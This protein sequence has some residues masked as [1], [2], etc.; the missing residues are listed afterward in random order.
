MIIKQFDPQIYPRKLWVVIEPDMGK[1][2]SRF[3]GLEKDELE[4]ETWDAMTAH[5]YNKNKNIG[6]LMV[7]FKNSEC[8]TSSNITHESIHVAMDILDY[9]GVK[10]DYDNQEPLAYLAGWV[11][12]CVYKVI[13]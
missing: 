7:I 13:S 9:V 8:L 3:G 12:E 11:T 4:D 10:I 5:V 6:G 2:M 1:L